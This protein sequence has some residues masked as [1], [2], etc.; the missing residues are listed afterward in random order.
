MN[1]L[2]QIKIVSPVPDDALG[3]VNVYYNTWLETYPNAEVGITRDDIEDY[4]KDSFTPEALKR[5]RE[6][7]TNPKSNQMTLVAKVEG[8]VVGVTCLVRDQTHNHLRTIY[9]L[10]AY[11]GKGVGS[12]LWNEVK[13]FVE[14]T[15]PTTTHVATYN[16]Q[17]ISFYKKIGFKE[18]GKLFTEE[19]FRFKSGNILPETELVL[20]AVSNT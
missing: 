18:T 15:K 5:T 2:D 12:L 9:V 6:R 8:K 1:F 14:E 3:M 16:M 10:P 7:I 17:A 19:R 20:E 4:Y 11:Q 13:K